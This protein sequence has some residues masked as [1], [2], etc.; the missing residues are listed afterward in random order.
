MKL[1]SWIRDKA[2]LIISEHANAHTLIKK[3]N[4]DIY[5]SNLEV[6]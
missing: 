5:N 2:N 3:N 4:N 6:P 1:N